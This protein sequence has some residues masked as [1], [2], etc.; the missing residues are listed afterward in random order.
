[1]K[2]HRTIA[3]I[4]ILVTLTMLA[5]GAALALE[6]EKLKVVANLTENRVGVGSEYDFAAALDAVWATNHE[7]SRWEITLDSDFDR[8]ISGEDE[9]DRLKTWFRYLF[10]DRPDTKWNPLIAVSTEGDHDLDQVNTLVALGWRKHFGWGYLEF[11]G[12]A[13]KDIRT[14]EEWMGD[15]GALVRLEKDFGRFTWTVNPE[16]NYG[17]LG[18]VRFRDNRTLYSLASGLEYDIADGVGLAYR[19]Q[20]NNTQQEDRRHQFLGFSYSYAN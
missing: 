2:L 12:G 3:R 4:L 17:V 1:M 19:L 15:V 10:K 7:N 20:L 18:E 5:A 8:S 9:Y 6:T 14:A 11:T 16:L 13:S